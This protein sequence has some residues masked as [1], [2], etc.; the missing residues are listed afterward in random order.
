MA[1][2]KSSKIEGV[3]RAFALTL[4]EAYEE[5]PWGERAIKVRKKMFVVMGV[6][7]GAL[8]VTLKL[9]ESATLALGLPFASPTGYGLGKSGWVTSR[10]AARDSVPTDLLKQ[11][12]E[13]SYRAVAPRA[14]RRP[15]PPKQT[16]ARRKGR[17]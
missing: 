3:L 13:E 16:R 8:H 17:S 1:K 5:F 12:I 15:A 7:E 2:A 4:P 11:W 6:Q 9:P 10:F 14:M